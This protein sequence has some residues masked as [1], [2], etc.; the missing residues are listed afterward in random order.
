MANRAYA[1]FEIEGS[2]RPLQFKNYWNRAVQNMGQ[3][4]CHTNAIG[5]LDKHLSELLATEV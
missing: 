3:P 5:Q 1:G 2:E 4:C